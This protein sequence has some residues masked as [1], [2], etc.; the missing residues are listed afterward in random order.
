MLLGE[1]QKNSFNGHTDKTFEEHEKKGLVIEMRIM[2][3]WSLKKL[4]TDLN[5]LENLTNS[6]KVT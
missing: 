5:S 4:K 2:R 6:L 3:K 1:W